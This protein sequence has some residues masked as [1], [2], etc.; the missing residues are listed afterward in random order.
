MKA[1]FQLSYSASLNL[2]QSQNGVL[3]KGLT[4]YHTIPTFDNPKEEGFG[5][6]VG[7]QENAGKQHFVLFP[8]CFLLYQGEK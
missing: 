5:N 6:T 3:W 1:T 2:E 7:K 8:Q 4:L